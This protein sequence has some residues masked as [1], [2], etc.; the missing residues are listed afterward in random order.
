MRMARAGCGGL[1]EV[2]GE[3]GDERL[4]RVAEAGVHGD[5]VLGDGEQQEGPGEESGG[6]NAMAQCER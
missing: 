6:G 3:D 2:D 4:E 1:E 5:D